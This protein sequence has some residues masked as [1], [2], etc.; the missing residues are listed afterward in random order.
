MGIWQPDPVFAT[1]SARQ[2]LACLL[3]GE[4]RGE[5]LEGQ[6][7]V[8][9]VVRNRVF[10]SAHG[11][12]VDADLYKRVILKPWAFS[13]FDGEGGSWNAKKVA[14]FAQG[15]VAGVPAQT[16]RQLLWIA[17]GTLDDAIPD[18]SRGAT[19]YYVRNS[20]VPRW[21]VGRQTVAELDAHL[22]FKLSDSSYV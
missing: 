4:T 11:A 14:A 8:A 2:L 16:T 22:F 1:L 21:A 6:L 9:G 20:P 17:A 19:H 10:V 5:A 3:F 15:V 18:L 13:C 7:A 12:P